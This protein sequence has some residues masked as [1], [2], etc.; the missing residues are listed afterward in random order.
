MQGKRLQGNSRHTLQLATLTCPL[1][2]VAEALGRWSGL[3]YEIGWAKSKQW[4]GRV[5]AGMSTAEFVDNSD[6]TMGE[7]VVAKGG[8]LQPLRPDAFNV[9]DGKCFPRAQL[10]AFSQTGDSE[11][12]SLHLLL[13]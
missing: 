9:K 1:V 3:D 4:L 2:M 5:R 10:A 8:S 7:M 13:F 6:P 11:V 12:T